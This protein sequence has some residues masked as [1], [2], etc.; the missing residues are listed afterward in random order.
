MT[1]SVRKLAPFLK[2]QSLWACF[3]GK[4]FRQEADRL[5]MD[6]KTRP[7]AV[8]FDH[9]SLGISPACSGIVVPWSVHWKRC[10][11]AENPDRC[12]ERFKQLG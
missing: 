4:K 3:I 5:S 1:A 10:R 9:S 6:A 7:D 12:F 2:R 8:Y 11:E